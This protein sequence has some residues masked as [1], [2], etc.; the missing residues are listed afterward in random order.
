[1]KSTVRAPCGSA[2]VRMQS[3]TDKYM[4]HDLQIHML[5]GITRKWDSNGLVSI[6]LQQSAISGARTFIATHAGNVRP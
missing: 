1:M 6:E 3:V 5:V 4:R 2:H